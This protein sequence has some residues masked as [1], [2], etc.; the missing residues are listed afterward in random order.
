MPIDLLVAF[1]AGAVSLL[2]PCML[3]L[4]PGWLAYLAGDA[5]VEEESTGSV[6]G[7]LVLHTASFVLGF[8]IVFTLLGLGAAVLGGQLL[9][10][11][12]ELEIVGG[13]LIMLLGVTLV[14]E[15]VLP[16]RFRSGSG[17]SS[18]RAVRGPAGAVLVGVVFALAWSPCIGPTLAAVL[19]IAATSGE[20]LRGAA[21]LAA[22]ALG[23]GAPLLVIAAFAEQLLPKVRRLHRHL[24]RIRIGAGIV[25]IVFGLLVALGTIGRLSSRLSG[26][27]PIEI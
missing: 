15:R 16:R 8:T 24:P 23:I 14:D 27:I 19:T 1:A 9:S 6:R 21:L 13:V 2:S 17:M 5:A 20:A 4:L 10:A 12:R 26:I 22:F 25:L 18:E 7:R 3:P 11:R